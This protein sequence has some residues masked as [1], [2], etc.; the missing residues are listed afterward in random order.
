MNFQEYLEKAKNHFDD[1]KYAI[2]DGALKVAVQELECATLSAIDR[3]K[4][5]FQY[6]RVLEILSRNA[7]AERYLL[8]ALKLFEIEIGKNSHE[9]SDVLRSLGVLRRE[10]FRLRESRDYLE[11]AVRI[12]RALYPTPSNEIAVVLTDLGDTCWRLGDQ[13]TAEKYI[14]EALLMQDNLAVDVRRDLADTLEN[15]GLICLKRYKLDEAADYFLRCRE[16]R[17]QVLPPDHALHSYSLSNQAS[18]AHFCGRSAGNAELLQQA[19]DLALHGFGEFSSR[20]ASVMTNLGSCFLDQGRLTQASEYLLRSIKIKEA[21]LGPDNGSLVFALARLVMLYE[22]LDQKDEA[23]KARNRLVALIRVRLTEHE[24]VELMIALA[25]HLS[26]QN[27]QVEAN[28]VLEQAL[29]T[30]VK[31]NGADSLNVAHAL[32]AVGSFALKS[33]RERQPLEVAPDAVD[34]AKDCYLVA[35]RIQ[36][37]HL[38]HKHKQLVPLLSQLAMCYNMQGSQATAEIVNLQANAI[39]RANGMDDPYVNAME[40]YLN[41]EDSKAGDQLA[42]RFNTMALMHERRGDFA[43]ALEFEQRYFEAREKE[44][45]ADSLEMAQEYYRKAITVAP[46]YKL[47]PQIV[48]EAR[49]ENVQPLDPY[50]DEKAVERALKYLTKSVQIY[51]LKVGE[52]VSLNMDAVTA[53]YHLLNTMIHMKRFDLAE[54]YARRYL[55]LVEKHFPNSNLLLRPLLQLEETLK[56]KGLI[57]EAKQ[58]EARRLNLPPITEEEQKFLDDRK[59]VIQEKAME[60]VRN[61]LSGLG[62]LRSRLAGEAGTTVEQPTAQPSAQAQTIPETAGPPSPQSGKQN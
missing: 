18:L 8:E 56:G 20:T 23:E 35:V 60:G 11:E 52:E 15:K 29:L 31:E 61:A 1:G 58:L 12:R 17:S 41:M 14:D 62:N 40:K 26:K 7:D 27:H 45:G 43:R 24:D 50:V 28:A 21:V 30:S 9:Y 39:R 49:G 44:L 36:R 25:E 59:K 38:G 2:A 48:K 32:V 51:E 19:L 5:F 16:L 13:A 55:S 57:E 37:K 10:C 42:K 33:A 22:H 54:E 53:Y 34:F 6:G 4:L 3:G 47:G 46:V